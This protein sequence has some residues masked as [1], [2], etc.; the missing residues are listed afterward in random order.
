MGFANGQD[1]LCVVGTMDELKST[2]LMGCEW[3]EDYV[4]DCA[5]VPEAFFDLIDELI[6]GVEALRGEGK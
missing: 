1:L 3:A 5:I 6:Q 2:P 4:V